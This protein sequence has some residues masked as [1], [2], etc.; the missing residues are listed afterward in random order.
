M[1]VLVIG[2]TGRIGPY[3]LR[4]LLSRSHAVTIVH[5]GQH[6]L[7]LGLDVREVLV[8]RRDAVRFVDLMR[9]ERPDVV[10][11]LFPG[12]AE[13]TQ[14]VVEAFRGR[15]RTSVHVSAFDVYEQYIAV[16]VFGAWA[17]DKYYRHQLAARPIPIREEAPLRA[18]H[19][20]PHPQVVAG[21][22]KVFVERAISEASA[23]GD[24]P[25]TI[26]RL[27]AIYGPA[28][29]SRDDPRLRE[30]YIV[31]RALDGRSRIAIPDGGRGIH[32]RVHYANA[33]HA[34]VLAVESPRAVGQA[35]NVGDTELLT[36]RQLVDRV[37][38]HIGHTWEVV[39]VPRA[40][41]RGWYTLDA[42]P[43]LILD[44]T[45]IR[46]LLGYQDVQAAAEGLNETVEYLV[47]TRPGARHVTLDYAAED[48][49][50]DRALAC[51]GS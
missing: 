26:L 45:K 44:L 28:G 31:K 29:Y 47:R 19:F 13:D 1:N 50:I 35:F 24:F 37:A 2:G 5:R 48:A 18:Q 40:S 7:P 14:A 27:A 41:M 39:S 17:P 23:R 30:W 16:D 9:Q 11:D 43:P 8:D 3:V 49:L 20:Y 33:A 15:I 34:V 10:V 22:D 42:D 46:L 6:P 21:F 51:S 32:H 36:V 12:R 38:A 25:A 4:E